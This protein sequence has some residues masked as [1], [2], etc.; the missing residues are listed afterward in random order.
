MLHQYPQSKRI[1]KQNKLQTQTWVREEV[2]K[3]A[4]AVVKK[5]LKEKWL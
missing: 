5:T 4:G 2:R 1:L 3:E